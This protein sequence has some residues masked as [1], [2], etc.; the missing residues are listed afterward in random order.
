M[1]L[2]AC[3]PAL[4]TLPAAPAETIIQHTPALRYIES[5]IQTCSLKN[6]PLPVLVNEYPIDRIFAQSADI[7][8]IYDNPI[9]PALP[10]FQLAQDELV[11]IVN[12]Q[13]S[14]SNLSLITL[15]GILQN[16]IIQWVDVDPN[17]GK[18][19]SSNIEVLM[20]SRND[21]LQKIIETRLNGGKTVGNRISISEEP[22]AVR[23]AV[24]KNPGA[25]GIIPKAYLT[26]DVKVVGINDVSQKDLVLIIIAQTRGQPGDLQTTMINC[27]E[28]SL[29]Q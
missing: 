19:I 20:Y 28:Q 22:A 5:Y 25:I 17:V 24:S 21:E 23:E 9:D 8:I 27:L 2:T 10:A 1:G 18:E 3:T 7:S 12:P 15:Q 29:G 13:N 26:D 4:A 11:V 16:F 14:I 6:N